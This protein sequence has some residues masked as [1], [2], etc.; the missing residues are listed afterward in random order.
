MTYALD[1]N[2]LTY[3][4][5]KDQNVIRQAD[6]AT[7]GGDTLTLPPVVDYEVQRG[8]L[9]KRMATQLEKFL[10]FRQTIPIGVFD[11]EV[12]VKAAYIY[13]ALRQQGKLIDDADILIASFCLVNDCVLVTHNTRHFENIDGL[14]VVDWKS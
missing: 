3:F 14:K 8:L 13:A 1:T 12:W 9:A 6:E 11:E 4:L 10:T 7:S 5:K 2:T